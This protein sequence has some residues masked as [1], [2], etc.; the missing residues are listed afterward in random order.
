MPDTILD[1][2]RGVYNISPV[3]SAYDQVLLLALQYSV[4]KMYI[5]LGVS[6]S[7]MIGH[8]FGE[9]VAVTVAGG[10]SLETAFKLLWHRQDV[11]DQSECF[12]KMISVLSDH[13]ILVNI[14]RDEGA[15]LDIAAFNG[16]TQFVL[17]GSE[18]EIFKIVEALKVKKIQYLELPNKFAFH[19]QNVLGASKIFEDRIKNDYEA[20]QLNV[21]I[22]STV[23]A[24]LYR[25]GDTITL[26]H[27]GNHMK[28]PVLFSKAVES[29]AAN[30]KKAVIIDIGPGSIGNLMKRCLSKTVPDVAFV[31]TLREW[32]SSLSLLYNRG[33]NLM[34]TKVHGDVRGIMP[35]V[36][37]PGYCFSRTF[38][39][40]YVLPIPPPVSLTP[41]EV[42]S[43]Y[44]LHEDLSFPATGQISSIANGSS[45]HAKSSSGSFAVI[46]AGMRLPGGIESLND[47]WT[48]LKNVEP[49]VPGTV[50]IDRP[51]FFYKNH[52][53][54]KSAY[55][56]QAFMFDNNCFGVSDENAYKVS[57]RL[58]VLLETAYHAL[59]MANIDPGSVK[60]GV[61]ACHD[62]LSSLIYSSTR[63]M[64]GDGVPSLSIGGRDGDIFGYGA[65]SEDEASSL[66]KLVRDFI[67]LRKRCFN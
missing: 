42:S 23:N 63:A 12:G 54:E 60:G 46:G 13:Q 4:A 51:S 8:S 34:W 20:Q 64:N 53:N 10:M 1:E 28:Q 11:L 58:R 36:Q 5:L 37:L 43:V 9:I 67:F 2:V 55:L 61:F 39:T 17:S 27:W 59:Q 50:P 65:S 19:S 6:P 7:L 66:A 41:K 24:K 35:K 3:S 15:K 62:S 30:C 31:A 32:P 33:A 40:D 45:G 44:T 21:P 14:I 22:V 38:V 49:I 25:P 16:E 29:I 47:F 26:S 56:E 48:A 57:P 52:T 18:N